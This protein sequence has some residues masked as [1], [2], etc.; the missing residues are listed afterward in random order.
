MRLRRSAAAAAATA[1]ALAGLWVGAAPSQAAFTT[2]EYQY[3]FAGSGDHALGEARG[4]AVNQTTHNLYVTDRANH[5]VEV[6]DQLG[7]FLFMFGDSVNQTTGGNICPE[8]A[9]DVCREGQQSSATFPHWGNVLSIAVDNSNGP[10][11]GDV[12]V[13][14]NAA[15]GGDGSVSKFDST[16]HLLT[17]FGENGER[18]LSPFRMT[19]SAYNG[20]IWILESSWQFVS[21]DEHGTESLRFNQNWNIGRDGADLAVDEEED[22]YYGSCCGA[23]LKTSAAHENAG[24]GEFGFVDPGL[25][26]GNY[27]NPANGDVLIDYGEEVIVHEGSCDPSH[28]YCP[29]KDSFGSG[30]ISEGKGVVVDSA[31]GA[32]FVANHDGIDYFKPKV[33]PDVINTQQP[34]AGHT[35]ATVFAHVDPLGAGDITE[36]KV[37]Y[38]ATKNYTGSVNC[39]QSLP[40]STATDVTGHITGLTAETPYHYRFVVKTANGTSKGADQVVTPH[41]VKNLITGA[42]DVNGPGAVTLHGSLDPNGETTHY[43]FEWGPTN[44]YGNK[45]P[46]AVGIDPGTTPGDTPVSVSLD[47]LVTSETTYHYR[48][49]AYSDLGMSR[50]VDKT[51]T[52]PIAEFPQIR[53][54]SFS[55]VRATAVSV[56]GEINPGFGD[57]SFMVQYGPDK[58][59]GSRTIISPS[60]GDDGVFHTI[61]GEVEELR[62]G[63]TY[64]F[65]IVAFNYRG[66]VQGP[67]STFTTGDVPFINTAS[68][69]VLGA[70][71]ARLSAQAL[72]N[73]VS[74]NVSVHFEYGTTEGYGLT[75][76]E[77]APL[78]PAGGMASVDVSGL[79]PETT[80]HFKA[81]ASDAFGTSV[82][83]DQTFTTPALPASVTPQP[84][85]CKKGLVKRKG[86]C[87]KPHR[88][89]RRRH[90][91]RHGARG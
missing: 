32:V 85:H 20:Y 40:I 33:I 79:N 34:A 10:S 86:K 14:D 70:T 19:V 48:I 77:S 76:P 16:G 11:K 57:T 36:C 30:H 63:T 44:T 18:F 84:L 42:A 69:T 68:A 53:N 31:S 82:G 12:Y 91:H 41:W 13:A 4:I 87:V 74:G 75:T 62:P 17:S 73:G 27:I 89:H 50:G 52:T 3:T 29:V 56:T 26:F 90:R 37:E 24:E 88:K 9:G 28:G 81:I 54:T 35:D 64:H 47:G 65:R 39:D 6:F 2:P 67:D 71:S 1:A 80:Y 23:S 55:N 15:E 22:V 61:V 25:S 72:S 59:Y 8:T 58:N 5:R 21:Y 7:N 43:Y 78:G 51:F 38:G 45:T 49:V 66:A 60:V 83:T 46:D